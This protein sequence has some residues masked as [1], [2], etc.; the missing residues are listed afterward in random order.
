MAL[1]PKELAR[2]PAAPHLAASDV[3]H[4]VPWDE[5]AIVEAYRARLL[6]R[7]PG[8]GP[9]V[10]RAIGPRPD[11]SLPPPNARAAPDACVRQAVRRR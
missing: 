11:A 10:A 6:A 7:H 3:L 5:P 8:A 9:A 2:D 1:F 4:D